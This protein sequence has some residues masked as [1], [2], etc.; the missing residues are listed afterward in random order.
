VY[1]FTLNDANINGNRRTAMYA[2]VELRRDH[3]PEM[4]DLETLD[5]DHKDNRQLVARLKRDGIIDSKG[6]PMGND[7]RPAWPEV[8]DN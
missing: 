6:E 4:W 5:L 3:I 7:M 1:G 2:Q 8:V